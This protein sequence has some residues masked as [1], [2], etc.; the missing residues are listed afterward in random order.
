MLFLAAQVDLQL[1]RLPVSL[2]TYSFIYSTQVYGAT[3]IFQ[4]LCMK[5]RPDVRLDLS[6]LE[7]GDKVGMGLCPQE[8]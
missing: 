7:V 5:D 6:S 3:T 2:F 1:L 4:A 8:S